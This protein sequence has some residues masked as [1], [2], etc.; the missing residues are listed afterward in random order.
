MD[1]Q[2]LW[3][4]C[5]YHI[6]EIMLE[7]IVHVIGCSSG[8]DILLFKIFKNAWNTIQQGDFETIIS[9]ASTFNEI[10]NI[11]EMIHFAIKKLEEFQPRDDFKE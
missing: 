5:R 11:S 2:M 4:A 3:L 6:M 1:E 7:A 10:E 8:S 9:D